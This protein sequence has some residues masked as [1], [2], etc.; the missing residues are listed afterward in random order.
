MNIDAASEPTV[1]VSASLVWISDYDGESSHDPVTGS[2]FFITIN[3]DGL[4]DLSTFRVWSKGSIMEGT[5]ASMREAREEADRILASE[6]L[7]KYANGRPTFGLR[8]QCR[9]ERF[10][11]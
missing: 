1:E 2:D 11:Q 5:F 3:V 7:L 9:E 4:F 10:F 8:I 6:R